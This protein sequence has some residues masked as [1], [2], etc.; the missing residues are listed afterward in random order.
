MQ[1]DKRKAK[2]SCACERRCSHH[3]C[4]FP[5]F[6]SIAKLLLFHETTKVFRKK[7][8]QGVNYTL[9]PLCHIGLPSLVYS[10]IPLASQPLH[11]NL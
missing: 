2:A 11:Q 10:C 1:I 8:G 4:Q 9:S 3:T 6:L 7:K 5:Y